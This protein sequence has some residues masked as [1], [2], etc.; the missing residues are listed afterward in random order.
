M[1][2]NGED[3]LLFIGFNQD[4]GCF[5]CGTERGFI[6]YNC[7]PLKERF[8]RDLDGGIGIV[9]MLFRCNILALVGGGT[10]PKYLPNKVMIWDDYQNKCIAELEFR[11]NVKSLRL[12]KDSV[13]VVLEQKVYVYN[14]SDLQLVNQIE[15]SPNPLGIVALSP[16]EGNIV[17]S[18]PGDKL[19]SVS[20]DHCNVAGKPRI[21]PAHENT[22]RL[23]S[24]NADGSLLATASEKGT[25]IR[26]FDTNSGSSDPIREF[27]RGADRAVIYSL[28]FSPDS[29]FLL[30]S[31]DK[32]TVH[33][34]SLTASPTDQGAANTRSSLSFMESILPSYFGSEWSF[35]QFQVPL[36][37]NICAFGPKNSVIVVCKDGRYF[38]YTFDPNQSGGEARLENSTSFL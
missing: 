22:L 18:C 2:S 7:D 26:V 16:N 38:K 10:S 30:C 3:K 27:R 20:L 12:R 5:A 37:E 23:L 9:E 36:C 11:S 4:N 8:R 17:L 31:S 32:G 24:L 28:C 29:K 14:F 19:G 1:A 33:L 15:T 6:I 25:L 13:V 35:C 34:F 21:I